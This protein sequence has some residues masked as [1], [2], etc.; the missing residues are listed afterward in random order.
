MAKGQETKSKSKSK[1]PTLEEL[2]AQIKELQTKNATLE[3]KISEDKPKPKSFDEQVTEEANKIVAGVSDDVY[4]AEAIKDLSE[5]EQKNQK[6]VDAKVEALK[7]RT[8]VRA[9]LRASKL[10]G[11]RMTAES[12][13]SELEVA[14]EKAVAAGVPKELAAQ[15]GTVNELSMAESV[16]AATA[17]KEGSSKDDTGSKGEKEGAEA[18]DTSIGADDDTEE[19][20]E[21]DLKGAS[22]ETRKLME[23]GAAEY[24]SDDY[25]KVLKDLNVG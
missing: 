18:M 24:G 10:V 13:K 12:A 8:A 19:I 17:K 16:Y 14:R 21:D 15:A 6:L 20:T 25:H 3:K 4:R 11:E 5:D 2:Q 7:Q 1:G 22:A 9:T 23:L